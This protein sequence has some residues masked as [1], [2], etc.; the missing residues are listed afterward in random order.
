V[1][2][3]HRFTAALMTGRASLVQGLQP[4]TDT[5][6]ADL[7]VPCIGSACALWVADPQIPNHG[8]CADNTGRCRPW[9]D[10]AAL[11]DGREVTE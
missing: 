1:K 8:W 3:C 5:E 7:S 6:I 4:Y 9:P 11:G 10:A 2:A